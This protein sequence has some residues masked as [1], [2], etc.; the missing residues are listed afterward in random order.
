MRKALGVFLV[1]MAIAIAGLSA[2]GQGSKPATI[3]IIGCLQ[4]SE[5]N[6]FTIKELRSGR[7][8][9]IMADAESIGWHVGHELEIHGALEVTGDALRVKPDQV[10][11]I[12]DRC[13]A[14][15]PSGR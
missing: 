4:R 9:Q 12:A 8:Y 15:E 10:I 11:Y 14:A 1:A 6:T 13:V 7:N 2:Q 3:I 5:Q